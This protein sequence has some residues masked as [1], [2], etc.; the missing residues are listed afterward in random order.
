MLAPGGFA[1][2]LPGL[3]EDAREGE[4]AKGV[5]AA[6]VAGDERS[7]ESM[8]QNVIPEG[9]GVMQVGCGGRQ[10][11][12]GP[13]EG[14]G[15]RAVNVI[16]LD[17]VAAL[18]E[19]EAVGWVGGDARRIENAGGGEGVARAPADDAAA[20]HEIEVAGGK[21]GIGLLHAEL[22]VASRCTCRRRPRGSDAKLQ[23]FVA[24]S[25]KWARGGTG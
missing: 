6:V 10:R 16:G 17:H 3:A 24:E 18:I 21:A 9:R 4:T 25:R 12:G 13:G 23:R 5:S 15:V 20:E 2:H 14:E 19:V 11:G 7:V 22:G 8:H 1:V